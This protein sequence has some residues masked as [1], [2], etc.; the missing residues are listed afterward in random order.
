MG[1]V[2]VILIIL[3]CPAIVALLKMDKRVA[4]WAF[5]ALGA[6]PIVS[7]GFNAD[8]ALIDLA[9]YPGHTKG[10]LLSLTDALAAAIVI[11]FWKVKKPAFFTWIWVGYLALNLPGVFVSEFFLG[12]FS[13]L[14]S[15]AKAMLYFL[16]CYVAMTKGGLRPLLLGLGVGVIANS[17]TTISN[18][19]QGQM[20]AS[21]LLGHRNTS[22]L[23]NNLAI[24][25]LLVAVV[26]WKKARIAALA[27]AAAAAAAV[28]GGSRAVILLYAATVGLTLL[29][30]MLINPN[31]RAKTITSL[32]VLGSLAFIPAVVYKMNER[33][34]Q[35]GTSFTL[36]V[37]AERLAFERSAEMIRADYPMGI[38][39]NQYAV[40]ANAGGYAERAGISWATLARLSIVHNSYVLV[41]TEGGPAAL[42]ALFLLLGSMIWVSGR[43]T[44]QRRHNPERLHAAAMLVAIGIFAFHIKFE[45]AIVGMV[46]LYPMGFMTAMLS[47]VALQSRRASQR[48]RRARVSANVPLAAE[49]AE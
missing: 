48:A 29:A 20:Q 40:K 30:I 27:I 31:K 46:A 32:V 21:G 6:L 8:A 35:Q 41:L 14:S 49:A 25:P 36:E 2:G 47:Y 15:P 4:Y 28:L 22:G 34:E 12:S 13:Y 11:H 1:L 45:W 7:K 23:V 43:Q 44:F 18:S 16:A 33:F 9:V 5:F 26:T 10:I 3:A 42:A 24:P 37:D 39:H 38:G 19:F 17:Y